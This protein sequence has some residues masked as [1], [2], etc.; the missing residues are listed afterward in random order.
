MRPEPMSILP[1]PVQL[2]HGRLEAREPPWTI[3][4]WYEYEER[5][6]DSFLVDQKRIGVRSPA[7]AFYGNGESAI[8]ESNLELVDERL[9]RYSRFGK[10]K[11]GQEREC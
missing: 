9:T 6:S 11:F 1:N 7:C 2:P 5:D 4:T 8:G 3:L 10:S